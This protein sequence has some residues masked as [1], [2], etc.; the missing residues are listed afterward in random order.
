MTTCV[1]LPFDSG[2]VATRS[3]TLRIAPPTT[4]GSW[5]I[6]SFD[7]FVEIFASSV[8]TS[9]E[10]AWTVTDSS[11]A[12]RFSAMSTRAV[13]PAV[14]R[15]PSSLGGAGS[16]SAT[17]RSD[18]CPAR[19]WWRC[20]RRTPTTTTSV[21]ALVAVLMTFTETP[22]TR[23]L[24]RVLDDARD[25]AA[26]GLRESRERRLRERRSRAGSQ[27]SAGSPWGSSRGVH[28]SEVHA[29]PEYSESNAWSDNYHDLGDS[30]N[31]A[32]IAH[33][34]RPCQSLPPI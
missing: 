25:A 5:S 7:M 2:T 12:P 9:G 17:P 23:R 13:A 22:G 30:V 18:R 20:R 33:H 34:P 31:N 28:G 21:V 27:S 19:G 16:P 32:A 3:K 6:D 10:L 4:S 15:T 8:D 14:S 24:A 29:S 26:F 11:M 1:P